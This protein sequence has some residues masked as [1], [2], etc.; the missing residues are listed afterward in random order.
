M[1]AIDDLNTAVAALETAVTAA[2]T[3]MQG[4]EAQVAA[5][6]DLAPAIAA[7]NA[8]AATLTAA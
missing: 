6:P 8:A 4:L 3:K 7:V 2:V 5:Q 1:A